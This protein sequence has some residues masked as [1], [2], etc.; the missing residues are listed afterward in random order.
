MKTTMAAEEKIHITQDAQ[1]IYTC[2]F[3]SPSRDAID[4]WMSI[5]EE[6]QVRG[7]W[8]SR[9]VVRLLVDS[10]QVRGLP[11]RYLLEC[12]ADYNRT[13]P[14]LQAPYVRLAYLYSADE[15]VPAVFSLVARLMSDTLQADYFPLEQAEAAR[16][17]LLSD[18]PPTDR[19]VD[20]SNLQSW[21]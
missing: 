14:G 19:P 2:V 4:D 13:Y 17:W 20:E 15:R 3:Y 10:S 7:L 1:G 16:A 6:W 12:L 8:Y 11:L 9:E 18:Q 5:I 21:G